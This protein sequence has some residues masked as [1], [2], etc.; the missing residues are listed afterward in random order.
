MRLPCDEIEDSNSAVQ[1]MTITAE[2]LFVFVSKT[3]FVAASVRTGSYKNV[4][5]AGWPWFKT[6]AMG[7]GPVD[8]A[9]AGG[10]PIRR[11]V[12]ATQ[13]GCWGVLEWVETETAG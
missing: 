9:I 2:W 6:W 1:Q 4:G 13:G 11:A 10:V 5:E 7:Q 12:G 8:C 3:T